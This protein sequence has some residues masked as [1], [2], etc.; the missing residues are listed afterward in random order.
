L[1][2]TRGRLSTY[3]VGLACAWLLVLVLLVRTGGT[4]Q[5]FRATDFD[6]FG[7]LNA[8]QRAGFEHIGQQTEASALIGASLNSGSLE[9]HSGRTSFRPTVWQGDELYTFLDHMMSQGVPVYLL[10]DG[11]EMGAPLAAARQRYEFRLV[12]RYDIPFYYTGGGSRGALVPL[13][14]LQPKGWERTSS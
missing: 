7:R 8:H 12:G 13:Y 1:S 2:L 4:L 10:R 5:L 6:A 11:L 14:Q 9:L 3:G